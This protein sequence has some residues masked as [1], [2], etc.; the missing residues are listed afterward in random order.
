[1]TTTRK[2]LPLAAVAALA[3]AVAGCSSSDNDSPGT[4]GTDGTLTLLDITAGQAVPAGTYDVGDALAAAI[5]ALDADA[6]PDPDAT[7]MTDETVNLAGILLTC[8]SG[9]CTVMINDDDTVTTTGTIHTAD[10]TPP[11]SDDQTAEMK[12]AEA[13]RIAA[14]IGPGSVRADADGDGTVDV[15]FDFDAEGKLVDLPI[16]ADTDDDF[17]MSDDSPAAIDGWAGA[18]YERLTMEDMEGTMD[19]DESVMDQVVSYTDQADGTDEAYTV[20]FDAGVAGDRD[21]VQGT[22]GAD[23]LLTI[24]EDEV[25][26]NHMRFMGDFGITGPHQMIPAPEDD[27][28]IDDGVDEAMVSVMGSFYGVPGEFTCPSAC[29]RSS[30]K[31]GNL[32]GLGGEWSFTPTVAEDE[33]LADIMVAGV[34]PDP[35]YLTFG[36]WVRTT[37]GED[38]AEYAVRAF[39]EANNRDFGSVAQV[40]GT[41]KYAGPATGLYMIKTVGSDGEPMPI[42]G[43]Q[44]TAMA[45]LTANFQGSAVALD[46]QFMIDGTVSDFKD[47]YGN[48]IDSTW[49]VMLNRNAPDPANNDA[50]ADNIAAAGTFTGPT[51]GMGSGGAGAGGEYEGTFHGD[52]AADQPTAA[53]GTF[54]GHFLNGHVL[55][56]FGANL[57]EEE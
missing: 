40:T 2:F 38:G 53:S 5:A 16:N 55:G 47:G 18:R 19:V 22:T 41:A 37:Q 28:T 11:P 34:I 31:D 57:V 50:V 25:A 39:A 14:A 29:S 48:D 1:M 46:E 44:F 54:D 30:D 21:G 6:I 15:P 27:T 43:G 8:A 35:D 10:Y 26:A 9:P 49:T 51:V 13:E 45:A 12:A 33:E 56:A 7:Y 24:Q 36:Y 20:Y 4:G 3:M 42:T 52:T 32:S 17:A 23:G